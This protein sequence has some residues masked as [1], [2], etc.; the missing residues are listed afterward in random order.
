MHRVATV[1]LNPV[2]LWQN[3]GNCKSEG[4]G[5][6][7]AGVKRGRGGASK[8]GTAAT[9]HARLQILY[10]HWR[11]HVHSSDPGQR[12]VAQLL[13]R[14]GMKEYAVQSEEH[15]LFMGALEKMDTPPQ[16]REQ[17]LVKHL[18]RTVNYSWLVRQLEFPFQL[19]HLQCGPNDRQ[20]V[21]MQERQHHLTNKHLLA[22]WLW[23]Q[24]DRPAHP[25]TLALVQRER[26]GDVEF[27]VHSLEDLEGSSGQGEHNENPNN[28][29]LD[30]FF[31]PTWPPREEEEDLPTQ[32]DVGERWEDREAEETAALLGE[33]GTERW[34]VK[35]ALGARGDDIRL[36]QPRPLREHS[37][38]PEEK[39]RQDVD[40]TGEEVTYKC[41]GEERHSAGESNEQAQGGA[42]K[43][44]GQPVP[45]QQLLSFAAQHFP[46]HSVVVAQRYIGDPLLLAGCKFDVRCYLLVLPA[47]RPL[48]S[49][50]EEQ[51][52]VTAFYF[53]GGVPA[54]IRS[55]RAD[56]PPIPHA[57]FPRLLQN[58]LHAL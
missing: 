1:G 9:Q 20:W 17:L 37:E 32:H 7:N 45:T 38:E 12:L 58:R 2:L 56:W 24:G 44:M 57:F 19:A 46:Q 10:R 49:S 5:K 6:A 13:A 18:L 28:P 4:K 22:F 52:G 8:R 50:A 48:G 3:D 55:L 34:I 47:Y 14:V 15:M 31:Y 53:P 29:S 11:F 30:D 27:Y 23:R 25:Q 36:F 51:H 54:S 33:R 40:E 16:E 21:N 26:T 42:E 41:P 43:Q 39:L 35:P